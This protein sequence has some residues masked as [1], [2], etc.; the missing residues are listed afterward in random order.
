MCNDL[1]EAFSR[2]Q[3]SVI[4]CFGALAAEISRTRLEDEAHVHRE[5]LVEFI[6][7]L[8]TILG[9]EEAAFLT[10][11]A[12]RQIGNGPR[13]VQFPELETLVKGAF[14]RRIRAALN[15]VRPLFDACDG[16]RQGWAG[17]ESV[18]AV[19]TPL[20]NRTTLELV[21]A[22][23]ARF[24]RK[25]GEKKPGG[26]RKLSIGPAEDSSGGSESESEEEEGGKLM[27]DVQLEVPP[28]P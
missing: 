28:S 19:L 7:Y 12:K 1:A 4:N 24:R 15:A 2:G 10:A 23:Q 25:S 9:G 5:T 8:A 17:E 26:G 14:W 16:A 27:L 3:I 13:R 18:S 11:R 22:M 6:S 20:F 21:A